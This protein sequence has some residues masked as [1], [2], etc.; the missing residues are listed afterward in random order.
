MT[1][2][3]HAPVV[4]AARHRRMPSTI[5]IKPGC[6]DRTRALGLRQEKS[7]LSEA[8]PLPL[9]GVSQSPAVHEAKEVYS[10]QTS[11]E[12]SVPAAAGS[13]FGNTWLFSTSL[14]LGLKCPCH[15]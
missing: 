1:I 12:A 3:L 9:F 10:F 8:C 13:G 2:V 14:G 4:S 11:V 15:T 6:G 7:S 5:R